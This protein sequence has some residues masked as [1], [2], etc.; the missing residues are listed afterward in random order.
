M[1]RFLEQFVSIKTVDGTLE[2]KEAKILSIQKIASRTVSAIPWSFRSRIKSLPIIG[3][4][5]RWLVNNH[6]S[7]VPFVHRV[8]A[9]PAKGMH[10]E[11]VLPEDKGIWTGAYETDFSRYVSESVEAGMI[12][13]DIG[14]WHGFFS[15][16]MLAQ[17]ASGVV[18]FEPLPTNISK[19]EKF[20]AL[21]AEF[22][23]ELQRV[24]LGSERKEMML[25]Q[26]AGSSMAK[27]ADSPFQ[28]DRVSEEQIEV[29]VVTL[30]EIVQS[31]QILPP[32]IIKIDI[33]GAEFMMLQ[34]AVDTISEYKPV[35]LGEI[36]SKELMES[37]DQV[38]KHHAYSIEI[39]ETGDTDMREA[40]AFQIRAFAS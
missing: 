15:G 18:M 20:I 32:D 2:F 25:V 14:A 5:Q 30:D 21:N 10:F 23:I 11:I 6:L 31:E 9:G 33:E 24:A 1:N 17:G 22:N 4:A 34:G 28:A 36:H 40:D 26:P 13:Y 16:V 38:L 35:I 8:D 27:L 39:L 12:G 19:L 7:N 37:V 29:Q 3:S